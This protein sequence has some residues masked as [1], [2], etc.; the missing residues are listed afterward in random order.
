[1]KINTS[2]IEMIKE[3]LSTK[4]GKSLLNH[5]IVVYNNVQNM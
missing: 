1:M 5:N 3:G 4:N 2:V